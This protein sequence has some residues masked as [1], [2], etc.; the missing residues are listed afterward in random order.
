MAFAGPIF[1]Q[2]KITKYLFVI[3]SCI[4]MEIRFK[5]V[6]SFDKLL[7]RPEEKFGFYCAHFHDTSTHT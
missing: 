6:E 5:N 4:E 1:T 2:P 3:V 7:L